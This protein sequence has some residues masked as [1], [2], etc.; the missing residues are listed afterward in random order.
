M[1]LGDI[2]TPFGAPLLNLRFAR[3]GGAHSI[4]HLLK[5]QPR[6]APGR[7]TITVMSIP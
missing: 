3:S 1:R 7:T 4:R 5:T 6:D 2:G